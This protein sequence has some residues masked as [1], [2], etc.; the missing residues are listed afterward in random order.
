MVL[1]LEVGFAKA[2]EAVLV[3]YTIARR[4]W[5]ENWVNTVCISVVDC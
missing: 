4:L 2:V 5:S 1:A 3:L